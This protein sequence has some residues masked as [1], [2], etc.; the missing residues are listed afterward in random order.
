MNNNGRQAEAV[1]GV[2]VSDVVERDGISILTVAI[3]SDDP[4]GDYLALPDAVTFEGRLYGKSAYNSD[5]FRAYYRTDKRIAVA[6][7]TGALLER[8]R[9]MGEWRDGASMESL[10]AYARAIAGGR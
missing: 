5:T 9:L 2:V 4:C 3:G 7:S 8:V 1:Q 6:A 10:R